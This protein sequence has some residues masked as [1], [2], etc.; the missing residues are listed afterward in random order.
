MSHFNR[1]N[2]ERPQPNS[3]WNIFMNHA[4]RR[5][6]NMLYDHSTRHQCTPH[7]R[8]VNLHHLPREIFQQI[9]VEALDPRVEEYP[10][11]LYRLFQV[12]KYWEES[13]RSCPAVWITIDW[14]F[15]DRWLDVAISRSGV[16][17]LT[18][19]YLLSPEYN[20]RRDLLRF[21]DALSK[22]KHRC[23]LLVLVFRDQ[24]ERIWAA[25]RDTYLSSMSFH[26]DIVPNIELGRAKCEDSHRA[27][28]GERF[29]ALPSDIYIRLHPSFLVGLTALELSERH[30][31]VINI[32]DLVDLHQSPDMKSLKITN[33]L[34]APNGSLPASP[35]VRLPRLVSIHLTT[36]QH[37]TTLLL[38]SPEF[39]NCEALHVCVGLHPSAPPGSVLEPIK[40]ACPLMVSV[41]TAQELDITFNGHALSAV[42]QLERSR[43]LRVTLDARPDAS[44]D[45]LHNVSNNL[46]HDRDGDH[47]ANFVQARVPA[48]TAR[49]VLALIPPCLRVQRVVLKDLDTTTIKLIEDFLG[50]VG[51]LKLVFSH[52]KGWLAICG[53]FKDHRAKCWGGL[54]SLR[55]ALYRGPQYK[56]DPWTGAYKYPPQNLVRPLRAWMEQ[57][58][59]LEMLQVK[60][61][62]PLGI[63]CRLEG[64]R[65]LTN[66]MWP[67]KPPYNPSFVRMHNVVYS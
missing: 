50:S 53:M 67:P 3:A 35:P 63:L 13:I 43:S 20:R 51:S 15:G 60:I 66:D 1:G 33:S 29:I 4:S 30:G 7:A 44:L 61:G 16:L 62:C 55:V 36:P 5:V 64:L 22:Y 27:S 14:A 12:S 11:L 41:D 58:P 32:S 17:P 37:I 65:D 49:N 25:L 38:A 31:G 21:L 18:F 46:D 28:Y 59:K 8:S 48:E 26:I 23:G 39:P 40:R 10:D 34:A 54:W 42:V 6:A 24:D 57:G 56:G 19:R 2:V 52:K 47:G 9:I 45:N